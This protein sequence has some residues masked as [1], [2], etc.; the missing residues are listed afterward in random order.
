MS[1]VIVDIFI[2]VY[3]PSRRTWLFQSAI[4]LFVTLIPVFACRIAMSLDDLTR[5]SFQSGIGPAKV[6]PWPANSKL[7]SM[8]GFRDTV[9]FPL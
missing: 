6:S 1:P 8:L 9:D 7:R 4:C 3:F 2:I 5:N